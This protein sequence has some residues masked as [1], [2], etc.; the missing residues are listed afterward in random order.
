MPVPVAPCT[1]ACISSSTLITP[2][3]TMPRVPPPDNARLPALTVVPAARFLKAART[4]ERDRSTGDWHHQLP[5][6]S[7]GQDGGEAFR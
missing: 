1:G 6:V 4:Y 2:T 3:C 5:E 7:R